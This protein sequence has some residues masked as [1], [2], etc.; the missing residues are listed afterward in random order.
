[1]FSNSTVKVF[2]IKH[3]YKGC[4]TILSVTMTLRVQS[5]AQV[6]TWF[7]QP[8]RNHSNIT[9]LPTNTALSS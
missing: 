1:M 4:S 5:V 7:Q 3:N 9:Q 8:N 6:T 2:Q